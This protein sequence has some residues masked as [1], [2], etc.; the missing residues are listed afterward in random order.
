LSYLS[1]NY[2]VNQL[3]AIAAQCGAAFWALTAYSSGQL[4]EYARPE[5]TIPIVI[6]WIIIPLYIMRVRISYII[7]I[8]SAANA[9]LLTLSHPTSANIPPWYFFTRPMMHSSFALVCIL[10]IAIIYFS[11][12]S[13]RELGAKDREE[14]IFTNNQVGAIATFLSMLVWGTTSQGFELE[15]EIASPI[16]LILIMIGWIILPFYI[17]RMKPAFIMGSVIAILLIFGI[18]I[19]HSLREQAEIFPSLSEAS[20]LYAFSAPLYYIIFMIIYLEILLVL[21]FSFMTY[22]ELK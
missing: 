21:F 8:I 20:P 5:W 6:A 9:L 7:G 22:K 12:K 18:S 11:F 3:G 1:K 17:K 13:F 16:L 15:Y 14:P 4:F 19:T 10:I 2:S